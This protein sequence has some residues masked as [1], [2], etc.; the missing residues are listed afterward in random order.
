MDQTSY[1]QKKWLTPILNWGS[2]EAGFFTSA[3][4]RQ[5]YIVSSIDL[6]PTWVDRLS[7]PHGD[8]MLT[9]KALTIEHSNRLSHERMFRGHIYANQLI[10]PLQYPLM[11]LVVSGGHTEL[12]YMEAEGEF[13]IIGE[14]RDDAVGEA[15]DKVARTL[16]LPYPGVMMQPYSKRLRD[17]NRSFVS[18]RWLKGFIFERIH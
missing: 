15:Y 18:I 2:D 17:S 8:T 1:Q 4:T 9:G 13:Q 14:T 5:S 7:L 10:K 11:S 12:V 6:L 16:G 3:T